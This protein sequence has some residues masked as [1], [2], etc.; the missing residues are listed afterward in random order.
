MIP[1]DNDGQDPFRVIAARQ[2]FRHA[3]EALSRRDCRNNR[4]LAEHLMGPHRPSVLKGHTDA[5]SR[6]LPNIYGVEP[7]IEAR[8]LLVD[9]LAILRY[10]RADG[11]P[12]S[13]RDWMGED[14]SGGFVFIT[15]EPHHHKWLRGLMSLWVEIAVNGLLA[16]PAD[17]KR[18]AWAILNE[19][20]WLNRIPSLEA[21]LADSGESGGG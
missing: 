14:E 5:V 11:P 9:R 3:A 20:P 7:P 21:A 17:T 19:L 18:R 6:S 12:F 1:E 16:R 13:V 8:D 10:V 15:C 2:L 4:I